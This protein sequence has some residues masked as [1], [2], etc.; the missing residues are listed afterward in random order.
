MRFLGDTTVFIVRRR[1]RRPRTTH[2][3]ASSRLKRSGRP[4]PSHPPLRSV[5]PLDSGSGLRPFRNDACSH[6]VSSCQF[7]CLVPFRP[8]GPDGEQHARPVA[9]VKDGRRPPPPAAM[10]LT[11]REPRR[12]M[13]RHGIDGG[14][15]PH[16]IHR[17]GASSRTHCGVQSR[18]AD[19]GPAGHSL[20]DDTPPG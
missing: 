12:E 7:G 6:R 1:R 17:S 2:E 9:A 5:V 18:N 16:A 4:G 3:L 14:V 15:W 8:V 11:D 10:S 20:R 19:A 13:L